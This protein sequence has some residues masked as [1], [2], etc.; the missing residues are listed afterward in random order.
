[1]EG[2]SA[3]INSWRR[4][5]PQERTQPQGSG[6]AVAK[7]F[8]HM[9]LPYLR[10]CKNLYAHTT[11]AHATPLSAQIAEWH[12]HEDFYNKTVIAGFVGHL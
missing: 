10:C 9:P 6:G 2:P 1:M 12:V 8:V 4:P 3:H 7:I 5:V 11:P